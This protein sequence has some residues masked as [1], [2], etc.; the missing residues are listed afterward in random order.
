MNI[1]TTLIFLQDKIIVLIFKNGKKEES[2]K[3]KKGRSIIQ[4]IWDL[5]NEKVEMGWAWK[6]LGFLNF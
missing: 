3:K 2:K 5:G 6:G 4:I 1:E